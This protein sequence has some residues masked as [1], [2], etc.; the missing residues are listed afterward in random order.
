MLRKKVI[1]KE[2]ER[3]EKFIEDM[4]DEKYMEKCSV[5]GPYQEIGWYRGLLNTVKEDLELLKNEM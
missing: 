4:K 1:V 5:E 2:L 3:I